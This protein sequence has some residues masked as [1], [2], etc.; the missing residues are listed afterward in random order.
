MM[1]GQTDPPVASLLPAEPNHH[2]QVTAL[3]LRGARGHGDRVHRARLRR[4]DRGLHLHGLDGGDGLP[5]RNVVARGDVHG[6]DAREGRGHVV[7]VGPVG[8]LRGRHLGRDG[9]IAH[10]HRPELTV[11]D[12]HHG[13]H[14]AF[15][16]IGDRLEADEEFDALVDLDAVLVTV[17]QAVEEL[18]GGQPR[19]VAVHLAV[20]LEFLCR[21]GEQQP[22]EC[23]LAL[24]DPAWQGPLRPRR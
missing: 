15:V 1:T 21:A 23:A 20:G 10:H 2:Q 24:D 12:A 16:G 13:A 3:D 17:P 19:G 22:V 6:D 5:G 9:Q 7:G 14:A 8:L 4:G 18:V 11:D